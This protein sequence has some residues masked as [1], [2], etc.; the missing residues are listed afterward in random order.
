MID[1]WGREVE[2]LSLVLSYPGKG[3]MKDAVYGLVIG[4]NLVYNLNTQ[5]TKVTNC[6][7]IDNRTEEQ[8]KIMKKLLEAYQTYSTQVIQSGGYKKI[9]P[10]PFGWYQGD[11]EVTSYLYLGRYRIVIPEACKKKNYPAKYEQGGYCYIKVDKGGDF[12]KFLIKVMQ[13]TN[14][15]IPLNSLKIQIYD[16]LD[17]WKGLETVSYYNN[18]SNELSK[19]VVSS[20]KRTFKKELG[21]LVTERMFTKE[22]RFDS[23][24][25]L[26]QRQNLIRRAYGSREAALTSLTGYYAFIALD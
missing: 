22:E 1:V 24:Y 10:K 14:G 4:S 11:S 25:M 8:D 17:M 13:T 23:S 3:Y 21:K 6:Y 26:P 7:L 20:K 18:I 12:Y 15:R 19:L 5:V 16:Y 2:N 9:E